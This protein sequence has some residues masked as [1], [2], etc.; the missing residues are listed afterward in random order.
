MESVIPQLVE[1]IP[2]L[3]LKGVLDVAINKAMGVPNDPRVVLRAARAT[4]AE[5]MR[6]SGVVAAIRDATADLRDTLSTL[7]E[8][9]DADRVAARRDRLTAAMHA[10]AVP[11]ALRGK[12][13]DLAAALET[14]VADTSVE[15]IALDVSRVVADE[16][17]DAELYNSCNKEVFDSTCT[18][19]QLVRKV[20]EMEANDGILTGVQHSTSCRMRLYVSA[21][22]PSEK[23]L[24]NLAE[25]TG[26]LYQLCQIICDVLADPRGVSTMSEG[27]GFITR[28]FTKLADNAT[29][30]VLK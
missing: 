9:I 2:Q 4:E 6:M 8:A 19:E 5:V 1:T 28:S 11:D 3:V 26:A 30:I 16:D 12:T 29:V 21:W 27:E 13:M 15:T 24:K 20:L 17:D 7:S 25:A 22:A 10:A 18:T 23:K 14:V